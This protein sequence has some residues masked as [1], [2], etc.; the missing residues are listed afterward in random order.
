MQFYQFLPYSVTLKVNFRQQFSG[1]DKPML[2]IFNKMFIL[3]PEEK[4]Y[5]S[6]SIV[7]KLKGGHASDCKKTQLFCGKVNIS[8]VGLEK[9]KIFTFFEKFVIIVNHPQTIFKLIKKPKSYENLKLDIAK[10]WKKSSAP[11]LGK[12]TLPNTPL[13]FDMAE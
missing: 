5:M 2:K 9:T 10:K 13:K 4:K 1:L 12:L 3:Y 7:V 11:P 6:S 8:F